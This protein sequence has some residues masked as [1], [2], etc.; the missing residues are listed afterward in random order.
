MI[1]PKSGD[2]ET[3]PTGTLAGLVAALEK[4]MGGQGKES[5]AEDGVM[6]E[7][8]AIRLFQPKLRARWPEG[9][10]FLRPLLEAAED[11]LTDPTDEKFTKFETKAEQLVTMLEKMERE[12]HRA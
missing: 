1:S 5:G 2:I 3:H 12:G 7:V 6:R 8:G 4:V 9:G 10:K 11:F